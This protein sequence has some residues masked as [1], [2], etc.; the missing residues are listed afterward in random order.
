M[1]SGISLSATSSPPALPSE[2]ELDRLTGLVA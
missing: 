1:K 2:D